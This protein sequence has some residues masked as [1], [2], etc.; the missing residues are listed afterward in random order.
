MAG[1]SGEY[2][3]VMTTCA[4]AEQAGTIATELLEKQLAACVQASAI[5]SSY[6]W[7]GAIET[8]QEVRLMIKARRA[9][10]A[11]I[12]ALILARHS[13]ETPEILALAITTGS[14]AYLSWIDVETTR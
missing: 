14:R 9:D 3:V 13:Y 2:V 1:E 6:R 8:S 7:Q 5:Q 12:E 11:A 10:Y 4:S